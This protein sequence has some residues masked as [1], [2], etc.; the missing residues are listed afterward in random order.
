MNAR[1]ARSVP[2]D[3]AVTRSPQLDFC[4]IGGADKNGVIIGEGGIV[5]PARAVAA[6]SGR[7]V[8]SDGFQNERGSPSTCSATYDRMRFV[9]MG[10]T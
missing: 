7:V 5:T 8:T 2:H 4:N 9:E 10:A 3:N 1:G 6:D